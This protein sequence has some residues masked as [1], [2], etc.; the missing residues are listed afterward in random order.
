MNFPSSKKLETVVN[1]QFV[2]VASTW[3]LYQSSLT[4]PKKNTNLFLSSPHT[5]RSEY[6][7]TLYM[8][9]Q[10]SQQVN[11]AWNDNMQNVQKIIWNNNFQNCPFERLKTLIAQYILIWITVNEMKLYLTLFL[12]RKRNGRNPWRIIGSWLWCKE[13]ILCAG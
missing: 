2:F 10:W 13:L 9:V 4:T 6:W 12:E 5:A 11:V 3:H 7:P 8:S 1:L